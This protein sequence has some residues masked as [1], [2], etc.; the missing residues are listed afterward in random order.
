LL[1]NSTTSG[2]KQKS[3]NGAASHTLSNCTQHLC[4]FPACHDTWHPEGCT[5]H[6][7][8]LCIHFSTLHF[9][10]LAKITISMYNSLKCHPCF[11]CCHISATSKALAKHIAQNHPT[12]RNKTNL[13][14]ITETYCQHENAMHQQ[15]WLTL[16]D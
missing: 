3:A 13:D 2:L 15:Q 16:L 5:S 11:Q 4:P 7:Q 9:N 6:A 12:T 14:L 1:S 10:E 8:Q